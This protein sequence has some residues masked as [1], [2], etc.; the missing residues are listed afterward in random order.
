MKKNIPEV[1]IAK[2]VFKVKDG[3]GLNNFLVDLMI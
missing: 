3:K 2:R 1:T